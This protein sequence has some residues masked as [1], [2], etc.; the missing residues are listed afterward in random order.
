M[1]QIVDAEADDSDVVLPCLERPGAVAR[2]VPCSCVAET[3]VPIGVVLA[4]QVR[5]KRVPVPVRIFRRADPLR[6]GV[7]PERDT[8]L[9]ATVTAHHRRQRHP[10]VISPYAAVRLIDRQ[11]RFLVIRQLRAGKGHLETEVLPFLKGHRN[12]VAC[13]QFAGHDG[14]FH[15]AA[16]GHRLPVLNGK[17]G[18]RAVGKRQRGKAF[19]TPDGKAFD[20]PFVEHEPR[21][22]V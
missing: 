9:H 7:A 17:V 5:D 3:E 19:H 15:F 8:R 20:A 11:Q 18:F 10:P 12:A 22:A 14:L 6:D 16:K 1:K 4:A 13:E 2:R 21:V